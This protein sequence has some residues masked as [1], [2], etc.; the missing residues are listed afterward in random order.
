MLVAGRLVKLKKHAPWKTP[1]GDM[2][3]VWHS[4]DK[5]GHP[6]WA[7]EVPG[8]SFGAFLPESALKYSDWR[9]YQR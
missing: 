4:M 7:L 9:F 5:N 8:C 3:L 1:R 6:W 2:R